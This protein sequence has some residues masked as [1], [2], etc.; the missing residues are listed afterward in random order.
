MYKAIIADDENK[1]CQLIQMLG[2]WERFSIEIAAI[3]TDGE[4][5]Y[6]AIL[7]I[8][9]DIV[10]T[11]IRMP[12]YDGL[13]LIEKTK[14]SGIDAS[15]III[16][17]YRHFEYAQNALRFGIV[18]Y[19]LKPIDQQQ[20][21]EVLE[22]TC[23]QLE[24][25]RQNQQINDRAKQIVEN[26]Y[27]KKQAQFLQDVLDGRFSGKAA[28][29]NEEEMQEK[30]ELGM[31]AE[32]VFLAMLL[33][34]ENQELLQEG[35][36]FL[37][38]TESLF[39]QTFSFCKYAITG[40]DLRGIWCAVYFDMKKQAQVTEGIKDFYYSVRMMEEIYG[41][42]HPVLGIGTVEAEKEHFFDSFSR[43]GMAEWQKMAYNNMKILYYKPTP[44][45]EI[46][47]EEELAA[48]MRA[49][50]SAMELLQADAVRQWFAAVREKA[51]GTADKLL[52]IYELRGKII[53]AFREY[54]SRFQGPE[55]QQAAGRLE[56]MSYRAG[57]LKALWDCLENTIVGVLQEKADEKA[58]GDSKPIQMVKTYV[59]NHLGE[60][61]TLDSAA[62][63]AGFAPA[64][65]SN[66]FKKQTGQNFTEYLTEV[67]LQ[68]AKRL[69]RSSDK[70]IG[71][72]A[73][74][75]GYPDDKYFRKLF[76]KTVGIKASE[77]RKL[78]R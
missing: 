61:I 28:L 26:E 4:E 53:E 71:E 47:G 25:K 33:N 62:A 41:N 42:F 50:F 75:A 78:Y 30:Y 56:E 38:K 48:Q 77:Y 76:K 37:Q 66:V 45:K 59:E 21:N 65:F 5:A 51:N 69:L 67:R 23:E 18:D 1:T 55:G 11:D 2:D 39:S 52:A 16:S 24:K 19:L 9:P 32:G 54:L 15:F 49:L 40:T 72:I 70:S 22:K 34:V 7:D 17:G 12:I 68:E 57:N 73:S 10:I 58:A 3:C 43:A 36:F 13:Q 31:M 35:S 20:L 46:F 6:Q 8:R 64:Y 27:R 60:A 14:N 74:L 29:L 44:Q 63:M